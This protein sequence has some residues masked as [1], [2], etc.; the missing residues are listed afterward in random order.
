MSRPMTWL[1]TRAELNG[2][3]S[4]A[5]TDVDRDARCPRCRPQQSQA[6]M[7]TV[8]PP[9]VPSRAIAGPGATSSLTRAQ[10]HSSRWQNQ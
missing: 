4:L 7:D 5:A 3:T 6:V 10:E 8:A 1:T 9:T 2:P